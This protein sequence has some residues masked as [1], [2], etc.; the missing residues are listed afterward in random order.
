[1]QNIICSC[2]ET[3]ETHIT[4]ASEMSRSD[5]GS[6]HM[7]RDGLV[8]FFLFGCYMRPTGGLW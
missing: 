2:I 7:R 6:L 8:K 4:Y 3:C 1:M 5:H